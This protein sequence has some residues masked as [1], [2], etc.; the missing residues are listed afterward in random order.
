MPIKDEHMNGGTAQRALSKKKTE[1]NKWQL[2]TR[3]QRLKY[4]KKVS[5]GTRFSKAILFVACRQQRFH[6]LLF[7]LLQLDEK[8][9]VTAEELAHLSNISVMLARERYLHFLCHS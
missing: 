6:Q 5:S 4:T 7:F 8:E 3:Y 1:H 9:S 2:G